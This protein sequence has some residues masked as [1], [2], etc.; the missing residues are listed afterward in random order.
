MGTSISFCV[1]PPV[2]E[3]EEEEEE[4]NISIAIACCH[5]TVKQ[6]QNGEANEKTDIS[7]R[8]NVLQSSQSG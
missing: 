1:D 2:D 7:T 5:G 4:N 8:D 6:P 3:I